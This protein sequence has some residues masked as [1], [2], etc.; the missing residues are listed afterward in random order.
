MNKLLG[1][2][3][4]KSETAIKKIIAALDIKN[5]ETIIEIGPGKGALTFP[6]INV[7]RETNS[8]LIAIEKD[9]KLGSRVEGLGDSKYLKII[10]GDALKI[11]PEITK[12]YTLTPTPYKLVGNIPYYIT[13]KLL[14]IIGE[15]EN[16]PD[17]SVLMLQKEVAER[18]CAE[19]KRMNP[20]RSR[21]AEGNATATL[22][23]PASNGMNLLAAATQF[24]SE[25][26]ILFS[27]KPADFDPPPKVN[28]TVIKLT[29]LNPKPSTL[30]PET[31][32][33]FI[34]IIFKQPRKTLLNNLKDGLTMPKEEI[35]R[36]LSSLKINPKT[37]PQN[38]SIEQ[39]REL[40]QIL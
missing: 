16:K 8:K 36:A 22:G 12:P 10:I 38:L 33:K 32:Y 40:S 14:R 1:Q 24:W 18:I 26:K 21:P 30:N 28:S 5:N 37:R 35:E 17:L 25:P 39:I 20:V 3:L 19:P 4:L 2:H 27:L 29:N 34:H 31:Y 9:P 7:C 23:R 11:L 15:L 13:G 6:L